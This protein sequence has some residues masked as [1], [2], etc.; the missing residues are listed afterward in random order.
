MGT[1]PVLGSDLESEE[2][3]GDGQ[4]APEGPTDGEWPI[5]AQPGGLLSDQPEEVGQTSIQIDTAEDEVWN[6]HLSQHKNL[7]G[8]KVNRAEALFKIAHMEGISCH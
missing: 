5:L 8:C 6:Y 4:P 3:T 1:H 2:G 7:A